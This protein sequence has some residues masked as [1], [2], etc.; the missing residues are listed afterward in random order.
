MPHSAESIFLLDNAKLKILFSAMGQARSPMT[1]FLIDC[2]FNSFCNG[3]KNFVSTPRQKKLRAM[4][5]SAELKKKFVCD[6]A[7]C[8]LV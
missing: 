7:L 8:H 1:D 3:R 5:H 2:Y 6:S 4:P